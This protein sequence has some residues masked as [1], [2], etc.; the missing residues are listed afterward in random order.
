MMLPNFAELISR[1]RAPLHADARR[2]MRTSIG[3]AVEIPHA[4]NR[5][6]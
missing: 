5:I 3:E 2:P 4:Q 6:A 1:E